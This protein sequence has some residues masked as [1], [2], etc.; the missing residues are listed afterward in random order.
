MPLIRKK[1]SFNLDSDVIG[2][3][4][5]RRLALL[6][7]TFTDPTISDDYFYAVLYVG[8]P[9]AQRVE[10]ALDT[11]SGLPYFACS[12][13][14]THCGHHDDLPYNTKNSTSFHWISCDHKL[15]GGGKCKKIDNDAKSGKTDICEW[16]QRYV[17]KSS[18]AAAVGSDLISFYKYPHLPLDTYRV[19]AENKAKLY[20]NVAHNGIP[21]PLDNEKKLRLVFG[22]SEQEANTIFR[23]GA[24]GVMG[25]SM[26]HRSFVDQ[27][28]NDN[29][30][31]GAQNIDLGRKQFAHCFGVNTGGILLFGSAEI[32]ELRERFK[33]SPIWTP[34]ITSNPGHGWYR[35]K[36]V[37][38]TVEYTDEQGATKNAQDVVRVQYESNINS[39][40]HGSVIDTGSSTLSM[41]ARPSK[42]LMD[43]ILKLVHSK[44]DSNKHKF[45]WVKDMTK[46]YDY[47]LEW[48]DNKSVDKERWKVF[49]T[50]VKQYFPDMVMLWSADGNGGQPLR[51]T[52]GVDRYLLFKPPHICLDLFGDTPSILV[53]SNVM[54]NKFMI[55]DRET[56][57]L[58]V[59]N[60]DCDS[61]L[62][63]Q[64]NEQDNAEK[65]VQTPQSVV[66]IK[67]QPVD[68]KHTEN[69]VVTKTHEND[70]KNDDQM[71]EMQMK[72][73]TEESQTGGVIP[74][75]PV[76]IVH[77]ANYGQMYL[78]YFVA[79]LLAAIFGCLLWNKCKTDKAGNSTRNNV[80]YQA[81]NTKD[82][83]FDQEQDEEDDRRHRQPNHRRKRNV[84]NEAAN[85]SNSSLKNSSASYIATDHLNNNVSVN[86]DMLVSSTAATQTF[87]SQQHAYEN[88]KSRSPGSSSFDGM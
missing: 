74:D 30:S 20:P 8:S 11:G 63:V 84:V 39:G 34:M 62:N 32:D 21:L 71:H 58:G 43:G 25:L 64:S 87:T 24:D 37:G 1:K 29:G 47:F 61:L 51:F 75:R 52:I 12:T 45:K 56:M 35:A 65:D 17:D 9:L 22:C 86:M 57:K 82:P 69:D 46:N 28:F 19:T 27:L 4:R 76:V 60:F 81:L 67:P 77:L 48:N 50:E 80:R 2:I 78:M 7:D 6:M 33:I 26:H 38:F 49:E 14:C 53:G 41:P 68:E 3:A 85:I 70:G 10:M 16:S 83:D 42:E 73:A 66:Q 40:Y 79:M 54:V 31:G 88:N 72:T 59:A 5:R 18:I 55:Y 15:C 36:T 13:T 23:Q 44:I